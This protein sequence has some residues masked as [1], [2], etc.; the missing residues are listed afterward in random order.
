MGNSIRI[1][2][3]GRGTGDDRRPY[4]V[5]T[6]SVL[7]PLLRWRWYLDAFDLDTTYRVWLEVISDN[8]EVAG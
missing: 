8:K 3:M 7:P 1:K 5:H 4:E 2:C 6:P